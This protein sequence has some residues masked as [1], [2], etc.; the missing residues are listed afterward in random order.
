MDKLSFDLINF[1]LAH[2]V[3]PENSCSFIVHMSGVTVP[4]DTIP[5]FD[6]LYGNRVGTTNDFEAVCFYNDFTRLVNSYVLTPS[7]QQHIM[8]YFQIAFIPD[9]SIDLMCA[10]AFQQQLKKTNA[11]KD[12]PVKGKKRAKRYNTPLLSVRCD[13]CDKQTMRLKLIKK[14]T[15][16][17]ETDLIKF[18]KFWG[19]L[20]SENALIS[21]LPPADQI[22]TQMYSDLL[23]AI[24]KREQDDFDFINNVLPSH[25]DRIKTQWY[26]SPHV[27]PTIFNVPNTES[28]TSV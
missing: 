20:K 28:D 11:M 13:S 12:S 14:L 26:Q 17:N 21:T 25:V 7:M 2:Q 16:C 24:Q 3:F 15:T 4:T 10:E 5:S 23:T 1:D 18:D 6:T 9:P 19:G 8:G 27:L 22:D